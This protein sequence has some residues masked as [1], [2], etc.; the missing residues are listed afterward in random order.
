MGRS[1]ESEKAA[2]DDRYSDDGAHPEAD[3]EEGGG[4]AAG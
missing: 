4:L 2:E 3:A 1:G